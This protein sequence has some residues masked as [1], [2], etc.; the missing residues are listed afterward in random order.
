MRKR[1]LS[2]NRYLFFGMLFL[3]AGLLLFTRLP[4][5]VGSTLPQPDAACAQFSLAQGR[6]AATGADVAGQYALHEVTSGRRL[7]T[8]DAAASDTISG[9]LTDLPAVASNGSW[10]TADFTAAGAATAVPLE[11]LNPA[12]NTNYGWVGNG[13]CHAIELQ[14]PADWQPNANSTGNGNSGVGG[15]SQD[16]NNE[17]EQ[18]VGET[19]SDDRFAN[20]QQD[21]TSNLD[22]LTAVANTQILQTPSFLQAENLG[23]WQDDGQ[24]GYGF[25]LTNPSQ[26]HVIIGVQYEVRLLDENQTVINSSE[27]Q[28]RDLYPGEAANIG[29]LLSYAIGDGP[30]DTIE[31]VFANE[32]AQISLSADPQP[33]ILLPPSN[34]DASASISTDDLGESD[35]NTFHL[36]INL[37]NPNG[38]FI[39]KN[40]AYSVIGYDVDDAIVVNVQGV[41]GD[42]YPRHTLRIVG[43][44]FLAAP[45]QLARVEVQITP[46]GFEAIDPNTL[47][48]NLVASDQ[49]TFVDQQAVFSFQTL[50]SD[51]LALLEF[52]DNG[53]ATAVLIAYDDSGAV[54]G[55]NAETLFEWTEPRVVLTEF[56]TIRAGQLPTA[57]SLFVSTDYIDS[58]PPRGGQ[59]HIGRDNF[60]I[61]WFGVSTANQ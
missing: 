53:Q 4:T 35:L 13:R 2:L 14:F 43:D 57:V 29:D 54:I 56:L 58:L 24:L 25:R 17:N 31:I 28:L 40:V 7:A 30:I 48:H 10:V 38:A 22:G 15:G 19:E 55:G 33:L 61:D 50:R 21:W 44:T 42:V 12:P 51:S 6:N 39:A 16:D 18:S 34:S 27:V 49:T 1:P 32:A 41:G 26:N 52:L 11:I 59:S 37:L 60:P 8:W 47:P 9:W 36:D 3:A 20:L 46:E 5:A 45:D 23:A